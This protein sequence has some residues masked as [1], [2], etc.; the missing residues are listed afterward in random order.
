M[1][2]DSQRGRRE[3]QASDGIVKR[4]I[5]ALRNYSD[6]NL[7]KSNQKLFLQG[8]SQVHFPSITPTPNASDLSRITHTHRSKVEMM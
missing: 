7:M 8:I 6:R 1:A 3:D 4:K 2:Q 5:E